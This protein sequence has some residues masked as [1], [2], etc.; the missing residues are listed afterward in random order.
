MTGHHHRQDQRTEG[1]GGDAWIYSTMGLYVTVPIIGMWHRMLWGEGLGMAATI[2]GRG[3][4]VWGMG[5]A[6]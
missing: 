1:D 6:G 3:R 5:A 4:A 2:L